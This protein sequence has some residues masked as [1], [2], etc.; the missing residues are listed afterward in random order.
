MFVVVAL[1]LS[2]FQAQTSN[3][4]LKI[5]VLE[6]EDAINVI[7]QKTAVRPLIEVRD[8]N[9]LPVAGATVTFAIQG[10]AATFA[11]GAQTFTVVTNAAGQAAATA[12][13]PLAS[14]AL[15]IQ[16]QAALQ[17]QT[18]VATI[19]QT[20]VLTAAQA[21]GA[22]GGGT[23]AGG[24]GGAGGSGGGLSGAAVGG[25]A[26]A[27]AA[28]GALVAVTGGGEE[29][30]P[31]AITVS[32]ASGGIR[33]V[34]EFTFTASGG[35]AADY[36]WDFGDGT[37]ASGQT[38][39][40]IFQREDRFTVTARNGGSGSATVT[41]PV[42]SL[43]GTFVTTWSAGRFIMV[44]TQ[45]GTTLQGQFI[46]DV[47]VPGTNFRSDT[48]PL[49]GTLSSPLNISVRQRGECLRRIDGTA[50]ADL[51]TLSVFV[52]FDNPACNQPGTF[53]FT[54]Q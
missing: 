20:N 15:Q 5:V 33:E 1:L 40:H 7:Q 29:A 45:T 52:G 49:D 48:S 43:T 26:G 27:A 18:A 11:G 4:P 51:N 36:T 35:G 46:V 32:P 31:V 37:T 16:V 53:V 13:N 38:V 30:P 41:V 23:S 28:A 6:G 19:A 47:T 8:R 39:R 42:G 50:S 21:A 24:V 12:I 34:T 10:N 54:R 17:G 44:M 9:N 2:V 25:I 22:A 14:G 3:P